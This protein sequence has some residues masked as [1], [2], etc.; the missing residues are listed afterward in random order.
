MVWYLHSDWQIM[1]WTRWKIFGT[2]SL[3]VVPLEEKIV[4]VNYDFDLVH[5]FY[6]IFSFCDNV[7]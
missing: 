5:I 6:T 3:H 1:T 7:G 4:W 2:A